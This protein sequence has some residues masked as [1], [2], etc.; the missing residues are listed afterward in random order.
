MGRGAKQT[1]VGRLA[2]LVTVML[3]AC[4]A[5]SW[6]QQPSPAP[7]PRMQFEVPD[8]RPPRA[9]HWLETPFLFELA[10]TDR[11]SSEERERRA[12]DQ[13][14]GLVTSGNV[15]QEARVEQEA[16]VTA[17][18]VGDQVLLTVV[19][20]DL[21]EYY[22]QLSPEERLRLE[23][24]LAEKWRR[25]VQDE[26]DFQAS[27]LSAGN[28]DLLLYVAGLVTFLALLAH[29]VVHRLALRW[30]R[31]PAWSLKTLIWT[32]WLVTLMVLFPTGQVWAIALEQTL[33]QPLT[34]L[35]SVWVGALV[36][37]ALTAFLLRRYLTLM[38]RL[39][40]QGHDER[41]SRRM[42]TL[43]DGLLFAV[44][45]LLFIVAGGLFLYGIGINMGFLFTGAG[46]LGLMIGWIGKDLF[47][48]LIHGA[49]ILLEDHYGVGDEVDAG[50]VSG[51]VEAFTLRS[52]WIRSVDG[53]LTTVPNSDMRRVRNYSR[54]WCQADIRI[55]VPQG[56]GLARAAQ[57][58]R[59]EVS[60]FAGSSG[61]VVAPPEFLG[62]EEQ[63]KDAA[64]FRVLVRTLPGRH[65][66]VRRE[67]VGRIL[68][69][70]HAAEAP[71]D[72]TAPEPGD[73]RE[74]AAAVAGGR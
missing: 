45:L 17:L 20:Q 38:Q 41:E 39:R 52:T 60:S 64:T 11:M 15:Q 29:A 46:L 34:V 3:L 10:P 59:E 21:P 5:W 68:E 13:L 9:K 74:K 57:V 36:L 12:Q 37:Y 70:L 66:S 22:S 40:G 47:Q 72:G 7:A 54:E 42:R 63:T 33:L 25:I 23:Y 48:D 28:T 6:A 65:G 24:Q 43:E 56:P 50:P 35:I 44:R 32:I 69:R 4:S 49:N 31:S 1:F 16:G 58:I 27:M 18:L 55:T 8:P 67:L 19:P 53:S 61:D 26:L 2:A 14:I 73:G 71:M 51:V 62:V 30:L